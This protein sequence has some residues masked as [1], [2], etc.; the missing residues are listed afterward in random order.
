MLTSNAADLGRLWEPGVQAVIWHPETR[1][2]WEQQ[3]E[4]AVES[5]S[6]IVER[7]RLLADGS[8]ELAHLLEARLPQTGLAFETRL[9][10]ID[11]LAA[12][13]DRL[14]FLTN[15][16]GLMLRIFAEAPTEF[17]GFHVDTVVPG[18][19]P[20]GLLKVYN[21]AGTRYVEPGDVTD[22]GSFYGYLRQR[23]RLSREWRAALHAP[24]GGDDDVERRHAEL[25]TL[26]AAP[27]FLR[28]LATV[29]EV[30]SGAVVAFRHLDARDHWAEHPTDRAW[31]H[32]S[33][34]SGVRRLVA[35]LTPL[36]G[37][38]GRPH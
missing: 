31:I 12:L 35:N 4:T 16:H 34:M 38:V 1:A 26:D 25:R 14:A 13:A 3:V 2:A 30:P 17:C 15:C 20:V 11:D 28:P 32:C 8:A 27:P 10:L 6:F 29:R 37:T 18:R 33:P 9:A 21:G 5:A 24:D 22:M 36:D 7:C 23:E 19:P